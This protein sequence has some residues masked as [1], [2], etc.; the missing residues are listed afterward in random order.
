TERFAVG[1]YI[2]G[3]IATV[4]SKNVVKEN[5][6]GDSIAEATIRFNY[7]NSFYS[8][9]FSI[10]SNTD[11]KIPGT[12]RALISP[13]QIGAEGHDE[14]SMFSCLTLFQRIA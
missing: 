10:V 8:P 14:M 7:L 4:E 1:S 3:T 5:I 13:F 2:W 11:V 12:W 6:S 9:Q